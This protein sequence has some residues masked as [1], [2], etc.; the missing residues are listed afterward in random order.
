MDTIAPAASHAPLFQNHPRTAR[1]RISGKNL[2][3]VL[4]VVA[5]TFS[6]VEASDQPGRFTDLLISRQLCI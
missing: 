4:L 5:P 3:V 2:F 1:A 6:G